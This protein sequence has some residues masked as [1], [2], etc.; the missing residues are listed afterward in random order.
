MLVELKHKNYN[1]KL[2]EEALEVVEKMMRKNLG[3]PNFSIC[4]YFID[5]SRKA[6]MPGLTEIRTFLWSA[7]LKTNPEI[8]KEQVAE[9]TSDLTI[10]QKI[11]LLMAIIGEAFG[12]D[13]SE[14]SPEEESQEKESQEE[15]INPKTAPENREPRSKAEA[16]AMNYSC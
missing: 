15:E 11:E 6:T 7:F 1:L 8:T 16:A 9:I 12:F 2:T 3:N 13:P 14:V 5:F 4:E 10:I